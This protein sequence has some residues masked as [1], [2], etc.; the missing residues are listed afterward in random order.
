MIDIT[1]TVFLGVCNGL[2]TAIGSY[3]ATRYAIKHI[4]Y[5]SKKLNMKNKEVQQ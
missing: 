4:D 2:G 1:S 5:I 3:L